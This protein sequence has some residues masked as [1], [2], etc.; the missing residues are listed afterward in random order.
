MARAAFLTDFLGALFGEFA[1]STIE[2]YNPRFLYFS[3][4][5]WAARNSQVMKSYNQ[6]P[7]DLHCAD[8]YFQHTDMKYILTGV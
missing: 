3:M 1:I 8:G 6:N 7:S 5:L 2:L 4:N